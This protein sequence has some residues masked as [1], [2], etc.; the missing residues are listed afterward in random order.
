LPFTP[1]HFGP[2]LLAKAL[3]PRQ[4]SFAGFV[5]S[6]VA[7]DL[8]P[9][10]RLLSGDPLLHGKVHTLV[11]AVPLGLVTGAITGVALGRFFPRTASANE[12]VRHEAT[13]GAGMLGGI[14]GGASHPLLDG[15]M[16]GDVYPFWPFHYGNPLLHLVP[17][18]S[19][20]LGCLLAGALAILILSMRGRRRSSASSP[21]RFTPGE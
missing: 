17:P 10:I 13:V 12:T 11:V 21:V 14:L 9:L 5:A 16:H 8:E 4:V 2:G 20:F 6:Q 18:T 7:I 15:L 1:F 3:L 19:V